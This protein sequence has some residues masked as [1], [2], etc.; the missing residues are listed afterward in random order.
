[1]NDKIKIYNDK[2][3]GKYVE[4]DISYI[5]QKY[6]HNIPFWIICHLEKLK[7]KIYI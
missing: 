4:V 1:M 6:S 3:F 7:D 5:N 2:L